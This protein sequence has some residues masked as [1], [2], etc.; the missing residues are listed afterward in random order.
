MSNVTPLPGLSGLTPSMKRSIKEF[1]SELW[2]A[3]HSAS[4]NGITTVQVV[5]MLEVAKAAVIQSHF[6]DGE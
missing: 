5:G 1:W 6:D 3:I 4:G 2:A